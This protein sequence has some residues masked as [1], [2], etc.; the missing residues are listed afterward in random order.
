M[1]G[2]LVLFSLENIDVLEE[3]IGSKNIFHST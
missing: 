1:F 3:T 2:Q